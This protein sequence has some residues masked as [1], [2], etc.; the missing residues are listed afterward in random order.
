MHIFDFLVFCAP[1]SMPLASRAVPAAFWSQAW[2]SESLAASEWRDQ[3]SFDL[4]PEAHLFALLKSLCISDSVLQAALHFSRSRWWCALLG[5]PAPYGWCLHTPMW[6]LSAP[7]GTWMSIHIRSCALRKCMDSQID[8]FQNVKSRHRHCSSFWA[9]CFWG[10][11]P[12]LP[13]GKSHI[14]VCFLT[15]DCRSPA[16]SDSDA[17]QYPWL[18]PASARLRPHPSTSLPRNTLHRQFHPHRTK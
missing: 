15:V 11:S 4:L 9:V 10:S 3:V 17:A 1:R 18:P 13:R 5:S 7:L 6:A 14:P 16:L 12:D 2:I 8:R